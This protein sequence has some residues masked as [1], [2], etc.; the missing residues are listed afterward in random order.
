MRPGTQWLTIRLVVLVQV[1]LIAL[2]ER[3]H[4]LR[5][6]VDTALAGSQNEPVVVVGLRLQRRL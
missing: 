2:K 5:D 3:P 6:V 1:P 4:H